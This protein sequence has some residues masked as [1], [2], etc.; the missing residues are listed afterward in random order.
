MKIMPLIPCH[1]LQGLRQH[2]HHTSDLNSASESNP[3]KSVEGVIKG[4]PMP[5]CRRQCRDAKFNVQRRSLIS[6]S[7]LKVKGSGE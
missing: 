3:S 7:C 2:K 5:R 6:R 4:V 1:V